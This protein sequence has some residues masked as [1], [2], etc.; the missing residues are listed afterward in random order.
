MRIRILRGSPWIMAW[1]LGLSGLAGC[2]KGG[3]VTV[4]GAEVTVATKDL[5]VRFSRTSSWSD[6]IMIF[7]GASLDH[8]NAVNPITLAGLK[9]EDAR[10]ISE[11]H[12]DFY[13][14][15]SAGAGL[16]QSLIAQFDLIPADS[17]ILGILKDAL[18]EFNANL[19]SGGDRVCVRL[20]GSELKLVS[21]TARE[22]GGDMSGPL[23]NS[24]F[25][26][27]TSAEKVEGKAALAGG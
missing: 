5:D 24:R 8:E 10:G 23:S 26:L 15:N 18:D 13:R 20:Q 19:R 14:C 11:S 22:V 7:G 12:P 4:T 2:G 27:V 1:A 16:S 21:A 9:I 3:S 17:G 25:Y 6:T